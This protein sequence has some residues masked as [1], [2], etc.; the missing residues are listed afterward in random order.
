MPDF[1]IVRFGT[2]TSGRGLFATRYML[3]WWRRVCDTL[4]F[5]PVVTQG[6]FMLRN[7]GGAS[8]SAGYH[9]QGGCF[10]LRVWDRTPDEVGQVIRTCR[11]LGAAAWVRDAQRG[12]MDPHIHLVL[13]SD[14]PLASGAAWQWSEYVEGNDGLAGRGSDYHFRPN[15]LVL[16]PP[17]PKGLIMDDKVKAA[18]DAI[19]QKLNALDDKVSALRVKEAGRHQDQIRELR[20]QGKTADEILN[21]LEKG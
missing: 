15:P 4:G 14:R 21:E 17:K 8:A 13:G 19:N 20:K 3:D 18:F 9:D 5:E 7:G 2:D 1:T 10:D 6:A 12:G 16:T 11:R